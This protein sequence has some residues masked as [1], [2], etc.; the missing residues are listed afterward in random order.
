MI[1]SWLATTFLRDVPMES[2]PQPPLVVAVP[3]LAED[4]GDNTHFP[5]ELSSTRQPPVRFI[6]SPRSEGGVN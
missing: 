6:S 1:F 3:N 4:P 2:Y 5:D